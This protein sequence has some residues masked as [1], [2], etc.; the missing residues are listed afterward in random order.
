VLALA[1]A[2]RGRAARRTLRF[3][4]FTN[5]EPPYFQ[6]P[7]MGSLVYAR[8]SRT[9]GANLTA[10]LSLETIGYFSDAPGSQRYPPPIKLFYPSTGNFIGFVGNISSRG[11]VHRTIR[12]FRASATLP[13]VGAALPAFIK[14]VGESDQWSFWQQGYPGIMITDTAPFRNWNYHTGNDTPETIKYDRLARVV[15]GL[16]RAIEGL[17]SAE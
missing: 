15:A 12:T 10:L 8:R 17:V 5:E 14:G 13:S 16:D 11:L 3:V 6:K 9:R 1:P 7:S 4:L 2:W